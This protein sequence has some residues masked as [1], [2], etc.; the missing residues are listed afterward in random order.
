MA[1]YFIFILGAG[2][3]L[4]AIAAIVLRLA[5]GLVGEQAPDLGRAMVIVLG[6]MILQFVGG[7]ILGFVGLGS[8]QVVGLV[9][10]AIVSAWVYSQMLPTTLGRGLAIWVAQIVVCFVVGFVVAAGVMMIGGT[11]LTF[12]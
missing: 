3:L 2:F 10:S 6:A 4:L 12:G 7:M 11:A 8:S 9:V 1:T 5:C